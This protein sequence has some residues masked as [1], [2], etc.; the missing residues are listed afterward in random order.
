MPSSIDVLMLGKRKVHR[1]RLRAGADFKLDIMVLQQ[2]AKLREVILAVQIRPRQR[3]FKAAR[4]GHKAITQLRNFRCL[5]RG[6]GHGFSLHA[7]KRVARPHMPRQRFTG[8]IALHRLPQMTDLLRINPLHLRECQ[9]GVGVAGG[10][11][12]VG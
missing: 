7:H 1:N 3:G 9:F 8:Y 10:G 6:A 5:Q 2:Q 11:D 4:P 12:E